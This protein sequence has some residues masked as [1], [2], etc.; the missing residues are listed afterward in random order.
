M[1]TVL[2]MDSPITI[3]QG[4]SAP[5][6]LRIAIQQRDHAL[7]R[8]ANETK[9]ADQAEFERDLER[10]TRKQLEAALR[11]RLE[12]EEELEKLQKRSMLD[13][14]HLLS[15]D[16]VFD[17]QQKMSWSNSAKTVK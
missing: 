10:Q 4:N 8:L 12:L 11:L 1:R 2:H 14:C 13:E 3:L 16:Y 15:C 6:I 9:R 17:V 5:S 7:A